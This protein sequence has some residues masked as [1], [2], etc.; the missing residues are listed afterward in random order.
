MKKGQA[1]INTHTHTH[2]NG[3]GSIDWLTIA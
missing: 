3:F 2:N 1:K